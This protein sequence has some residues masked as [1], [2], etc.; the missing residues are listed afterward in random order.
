MAK[1]TIL[2]HVP[3]EGPARIAE[4]LERRGVTIEIVHAHRGDAVPALL[5]SDEL[6]VVLGGPMSVTDLGSP[7]Y[8]FLEPEVALLR[9][10]IAADAPTLGVCLGAQLLAHAAGSRVYPHRSPRGEAI[11][12]VGW[13]DLDLLLSTRDHALRDLPAR[14]PMFHW[15]GDTFDL[16]VGATLLASTARCSA[17]AYRLKQRCFGLQ[18]HCEMERADI[19]RL[20]TTDLEYAQS[21]LG[22]DAQSRVRTDTARYL[23]PS[24]EVSTRLLENIL[25]EMTRS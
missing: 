4:C 2:Q 10:R 7:E 18:F 6:L 21:A 5:P 9:A 23:E 3:F 12:E 14:T 11:R 24:R 17:Q 25:D 20:L 1:A 22:A 8:P 15:H 16:P 19:E 13:A